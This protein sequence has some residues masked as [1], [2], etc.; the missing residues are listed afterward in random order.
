MSQHWWSS[1]PSLQPNSGGVPQW[2]T[3][4]PV[5]PAP[6]NA[7]W[8][9]PTQATNWN[10]PYGPQPAPAPSMAPVASAAP[11]NPAMAAP[12]AAGGLAANLTAGKDFKYN[13][14]QAANAPNAAWSNANTV[15]NG[16]GTAANLGLGIYGMIQAD[17]AFDFQKNMSD[18]N[19]AASIASYNSN[20]QTQLENRHSGLSAAERDAKVQAEM[21]K[22]QISD[23][24]PTK[25]KK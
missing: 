3:G 5:A 16:I 19:L 23:T 2:G 6:M 7:G 21:A 10:I 22:R 13:Q 1:L 18:Q 20:L 24:R 12:G 14:T 15:I 9:M 11:G 8:G 25:P 4:A 17:R